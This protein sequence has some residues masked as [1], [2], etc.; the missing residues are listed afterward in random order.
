MGGER[1]RCVAPRS[2]RRALVRP[3]V[4][5]WVEVEPVVP[6]LDRIVR[7]LP[8]KNSLRRAS[9]HHRG[10][11]EQVIVA[12]VD[13]LLVVGSVAE[14]R[15]NPGLMDRFMVAAWRDDI[16]PILCITKVDLPLSDWARAVIASYEDLDIPIVRTSAVTGEGLD[17]L[18][19][20]IEGATTALA[21]L[22]GTGKT[23]L[24]RHLTGDFTLEIGEISRATG[25]GRHVTTSARLLAVAGLAD[26]YVVDLPGQRVFGLVDVTPEELMRG[27]P[28]L[29]KFGPCLLPS[30]RHRGEPGCALREAVDKGLVPLRRLDAL[31]RIW[32]SL[33]EEGMLK[34]EGKTRRS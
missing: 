34:V 20:L 22:S 3:V 28:D 29:Q 32:R 19:S 15:L 23:T 30:C 8:R 14:P 1:R 17:R 27:F 18:R 2:V 4:G 12:N 33:E 9:V 13:R 5:D 11:S 10:R 6:D 25:R 21:G 7:V 26:T 24:V 31:R 16:Q